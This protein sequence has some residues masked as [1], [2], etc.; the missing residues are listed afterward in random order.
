[1]EGLPTNWVFQ[2]YQDVAGT[3]CQYEYQLEELHKELLAE[4]KNFGMFAH[5]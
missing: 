2:R 1:M 3:E 4:L 5:K